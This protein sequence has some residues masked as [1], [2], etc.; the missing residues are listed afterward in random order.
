MESIVSDAYAVHFNTV[1]YT[2]LNT[3]LAVAN[4]SIIYILVDENTHELCLPQFMAEISG[5]YDF[6]LG[7][8]GSASTIGQAQE[9]VLVIVGVL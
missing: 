2:S 1:A 5:T 8:L 4:Y 3:H 7:W 6:V 9:L